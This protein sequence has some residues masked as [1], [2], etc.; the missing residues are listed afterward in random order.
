MNVS[1]ARFEIAATRHAPI[2]VT[3]QHPTAD[4]LPIVRCNVQLIPQLRSAQV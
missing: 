1:I 4:G 3:L 2:A